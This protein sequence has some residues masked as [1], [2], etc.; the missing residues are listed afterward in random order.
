MKRKMRAACRFDKAYLATVTQFIMLL[1]SWQ[2]LLIVGT[3]VYECHMR[4]SA[5]C[6]IRRASDA[7]I[8]PVES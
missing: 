6:H 5:F 7:K 8:K 4:H 3:S 1:I 2:R